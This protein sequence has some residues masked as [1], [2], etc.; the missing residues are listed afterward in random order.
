MPELFCTTQQL[1][2]LQERAN[3]RAYLSGEHFWEE[4]HADRQGAEKLKSPWKEVK[5]GDLVHHLTAK[6]D[7]KRLAVVCAA[8]LGKTTNL[9]WIAKELAKRDRRQV[10]FLFKL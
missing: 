9:E 10:P 3:P 7:W 5:R 8:G 6:G 4:R 2:L 1:S